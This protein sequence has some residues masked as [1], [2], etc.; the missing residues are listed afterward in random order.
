MSSL[1]WFGCC[2]I[3]VVPIIFPLV[4]WMSSVKIAICRQLSVYF[5]NFWLK[6]SAIRLNSF[7]IRMNHSKWKKNHSILCRNLIAHEQV[8]V[9][10]WNAIA[11]DKV[12]RKW[13]SVFFFS[14]YFAKLEQ[15]WINWNERWIKR[16]PNECEI[17]YW[18]LRIFFLSVFFAVVF[19]CS[20]FSFTFIVQSLW[21]YLSVW[22]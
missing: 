18:N 9:I 20:P 19:V 14:R 21:I 3:F 11:P 10:G 15:M 1:R 7:A 13:S 6:N 2:C 5:L 4:E 17:S 22:S 16:K 12:W 8:Y